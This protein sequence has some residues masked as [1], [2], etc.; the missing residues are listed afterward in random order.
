MYG[1]ATVSQMVS[2]VI[3]LTVDILLWQNNSTR[4]IKMKARIFQQKSTSL[5][6]AMFNGAFIKKPMLVMKNMLKAPSSCG[7]LSKVVLAQ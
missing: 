2:D 6:A 5:A 4:V 3:P 7:A 1:V